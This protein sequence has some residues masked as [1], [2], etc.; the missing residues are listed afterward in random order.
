MM[1]VAKESVR[2]AFCVE[3]VQ[4]AEFVLIYFVMNCHFGGHFV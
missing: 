4:F 2:S 1:P 3:S